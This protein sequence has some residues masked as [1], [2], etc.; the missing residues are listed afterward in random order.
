MSIPCSEDKEFLTSL[1]RKYAPFSGAKAGILG[2]GTF[3]EK[4]AGC[5]MDASMH[6]LLCDPL[7]QQAESEDV[8]DAFQESW[9]NGMGRC[10]Y[11]DTL[12]ETFF[13]FSFL[14]KEC[15]ILS[16]QI[17]ENKENISLITPEIFSQMKPHALIFNFSSKKIVPFEDERILFFGE[18]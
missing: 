15:D 17:P 3:G 18:E 4:I 6:I 11:S 5:A 10:Y 8:F 12:T 13:P 2:Y 14:V 9:G 1:F 7:L 16:I